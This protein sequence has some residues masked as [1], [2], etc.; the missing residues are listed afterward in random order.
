VVVVVVVVVVV[1]GSNI[2]NQKP[3]ILLLLVD[4]VM[5]RWGNRTYEMFSHC[6]AAILSHWLC[7]KCKNR[8]L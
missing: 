6:R 1:G 5:C 7:N 3:T 8:S 4:I 2:Q